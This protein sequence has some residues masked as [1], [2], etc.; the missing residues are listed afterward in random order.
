MLCHQLLCQ[1][2]DKEAYSQLRT[3]EQLVNPE[4]YTLHPTPYTLHPTPYTLHPV[5]YTL[6][7][8]RSSAPASSW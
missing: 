3:R 5:P 2:L 6:H 8:T 1:M 7:P 4:P